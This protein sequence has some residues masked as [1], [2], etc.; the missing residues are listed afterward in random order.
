MH[1]ILRSY[2]QLPEQLPN[3][4]LPKMS[5][6]KLSVTKCCYKRTKHKK[7][8]QLVRFRNNNDHESFNQSLV[9]IQST[10]QKPF[11]WLTYWIDWI[12]QIFTHLVISV[13]FDESQGGFVKGSGFCRSKITENSLGSFAIQLKNQLD[14]L[15][16][17]IRRILCLYKQ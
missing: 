9:A 4:Q 7:F 11:F 16:K 12:H 15:N 3:W 2:Y 10:V 17:I 8:P 13:R 6:N 1:T 14:D 5:V